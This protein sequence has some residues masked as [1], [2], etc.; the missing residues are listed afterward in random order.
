MDKKYLLFANQY[1]KFDWNTKR[2]TIECLSHQSCSSF[3]LIKI[4][5]TDR[6]PDGSKKPKQA[7]IAE[8]WNTH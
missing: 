8:F 7:R 1:G 5:M 3:R 4:K 2:N 6:N